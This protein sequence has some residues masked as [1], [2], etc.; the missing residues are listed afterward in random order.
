MCMSNPQPFLYKR[1]KRVWFLYVTDEQAVYE[2]NI[3]P[4]IPAWERRYRHLSALER[5][6]KIPGRH[7]SSVTFMCI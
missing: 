2:Q 3:A 1:G 5:I 6:P 7:L 4:M